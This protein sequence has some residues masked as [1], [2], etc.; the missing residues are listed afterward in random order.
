MEVRFCFKQQQTNEI[1]NVPLHV[2]PVQAFP[3]QVKNSIC[4]FP[5]GVPCT[6]GSGISSEELFGYVD[7]LLAVGLHQSLR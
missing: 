6:P 4:P 1:L 2:G 3:C 7:H 5:L